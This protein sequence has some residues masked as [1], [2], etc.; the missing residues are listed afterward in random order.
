VLLELEGVTKRFGGVVAL[1]GLELRVE[2]GTIHGLIGPNGSGKTTALNVISGL[3][4]PDGGQ[5]RLAGRSIAGLPP[6]RLA[7]LG[8][9][10]TFQN[11][12]LFGEL[13][14]LE[15][16]QVGQHRR[17]R[18]PLA[19][20]LLGL[21]AAG[22]A[23]R[24]SAVE[25]AEL[26]RQLGL[27]GM[28]ALQAQDLAHGRQ[29]Q[30]ELARALA[31]RPTLLLL[32]EPAA[33]LSGAEIAALRELI[34]HARAEGLTVLLV[35][36]HLDL[37]LD[38]CDRVTVLDRGRAIADG[39]PAEIRS[40]PAVARAYLG[41]RTA[42]ESNTPG[43]RPQ[44]AGSPTSSVQRPASSGPVQRRS[45]MPRPAAVNEDSGTFNLSPGTADLVPGTR[46]ALL[47]VQRATV[48]Y[49]RVTA[50]DKLDLE[51]W[52]GEIVAVLGANGAGKSTLLRAVSGLV[53]LAEGS[54][55]L[56]GRHLGS[57]A[58]YRRP[59]LGLT[60]VPEGRLVF[61][62]QPVEDNLRLGAYHRTF[63]PGR[64]EIQADLERL[65]ARFPALAERRRVSAGSLSG[66][67]Q[68]QLA[69]ARALMA[70]PT[71]L[72]LDEPSL[73]LAPILVDQV[74]ELI[75]ELRQEGVTIL[76]V[77]QLA[78]RALDLADRAYV[79]QTGRR[80]LS[81]AASAVARDPGLEAAY[82]GTASVASA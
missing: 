33:G 76:L 75:A 30:V 52:R 64:A 66:G 81:G 25:A 2:G 51:V 80:V 60:Q 77:E 20:T 41:S 15:N 53:A 11:L 67:E 10:R 78:Y 65:L 47:E 16:V 73:G 21:P 69:I 37:I 34:E 14:V 39:T 40:D 3:Y 72:L 55:R 43:P 17:C 50:V 42:F 62:D 1:E 4:Q 27:G 82:L 9:A 35:E 12:R 45:E 71:L 7:G 6:H 18:P 13:T 68:Q 36:H 38:L 74:F 61:A 58:A 49:G 54:I 44:V 57:I 63:R 56:D 29:R 59:R 24:G 31:A 28:L 19:A 46:G 26:A 48:R 22:E 8:L 79:L 70:R 32:D 23:E 5:V